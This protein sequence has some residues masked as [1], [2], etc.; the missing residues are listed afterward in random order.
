MALDPKFW[1]EG[2]VTL[3]K[4]SI[5]LDESKVKCLWREISKVEVNNDEEEE[6]LN[7]AMKNP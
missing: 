6:S 5:A 1:I 4:I 3:E 2:S 7:Y